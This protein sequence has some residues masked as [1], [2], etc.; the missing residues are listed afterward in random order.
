MRL[1]EGL[2]DIERY[3]DFVSEQVADLDS[4]VL[5]G[6]SF[7]AKQD[8]QRF[9]EDPAIADLIEHGEFENAHSVVE[10]GCGTG[11]L[12][13]TLLEGHLASDSRYLCLDVSS[14]MVSLSQDRL[15][16][17]GRR[18]R[19]LL[20]DGE[21]RLQ[22]RSNDFDRFI[23]TYVLDLLSV[24]DIVSMVAEAQRILCPG[25]LL[26]LISLT[27]GVSVLSRLLEKAWMAVHSFRPSMVGG[28]RPISLREFITDPVWTIKHRQRASRLG[29][30]SEVLIAQK[31]QH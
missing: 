18:V 30:S 9:Y 10:F 29:I 13:E 19:V 2:D 1:P 27:H 3:A 8:W 6:D 31:P 4:Y 16:R 12:A 7:G 14:T 24:D 21:T 20:T 5:L 23:A 17:F 28:C 26:E 15:A 25:G 11:R 22:L